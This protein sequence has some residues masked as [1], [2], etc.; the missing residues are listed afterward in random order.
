M[1]HFVYDPMIQALGT[2][3]LHSFWQA[4]LLALVLWLLSRNSSLSASKRYWLGM[5][6]LGVQLL[7]SLA[8]LAFNY[9]P[10]GKGNEGVVTVFNWVEGFD[11][12]TVSSFSTAALDFDLT[13]LEKIYFG[14]ALV[15]LLGLVFGSLRLIGG[16]LYVRARFR[17]QLLPIPEK[18]EKMAHALAGQLKINGE[19]VLDRIRLTTRVSSPL[20]IGLLR[21]LILFPFSMVNQLDP[22]EVEA[23]LA[24]ELSHYAAKDHWWNFAQSCVEILF[25]FNPAVHWIGKRIREEREFRC[26]YH[27]SELGIDPIIYATSL[28]RIEEQRLVAAQHALSARPGSLLSRIERLLRNTP[29]YYHMKPGLLLFLLLLVGTLFSSRPSLPEL[30][31]EILLENKLTAEELT[32]TAAQSG[33]I[34]SLSDTI[35]PRSESRQVIVM[36]RNGEEVEL[37]KINGKISR[38]QIDGRVIPPSE[39]GNHTALVRE[40]ENVPP[41]PAPPTPPVPPTPGAV[42]TPPVP[43]TPPAPPRP[44][45]SDFFGQEFEMDINEDRMIFNI[46]GTDSVFNMDFQELGNLSWLGEVFSRI[47]ADGELSR[48]DEMAIEAAAEE[49]KDNL[50]VMRKDLKKMGDDMKSLFNMKFQTDEEEGSFRILMSTEDGER[51]VFEMYGNEEQPFHMEW[52]D[53]DGAVHRLAEVMEEI[54]LDGIQERFEDARAREN[55][56]IIIDGNARALAEM[57]ELRDIEASALFGSA[58]REGGVHKI[59]AQKFISLAKEF[60]RR[61]LIDGSKVSS[62]DINSKKMKI[63][64]KKVSSELF[65]RYVREYESRHNIGW[66]ELGKF[67]IE[68]SDL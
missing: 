8:T 16:H 51:E 58:R 57:N 63:N 37:E 50:F 1:I 52:T 42:P 3:V 30:F 24:H 17:K 12:P 6:A 13:L 39:Y 66:L 28:Y 53:E 64:G 4:T 19:D 43:P 55:R 62:I 29:N 40:L 49:W 67:N 34:A 36:Q 27:V 5:G 47:D 41:P 56:A 48:E 21:P 60:Q 9:E 2:T 7:A 11:Q 23:L 68:L 26:D 45:S 15:W 25:Y 14:L 59:S 10:P 22:E 54:E 18:W 65:D 20:M 35:K 33:E 46:P 44:G 32:A 31:P 61:G 38:L